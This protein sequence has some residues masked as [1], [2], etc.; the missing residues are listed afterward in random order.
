LSIQRFAVSGSTTVAV[1][2]IA[3]AI[4]DA[5]GVTARTGLR[6]NVMIPVTVNAA[7]P[8]SA[9]RPRGP[10]SRFMLVSQT[11]S[12]INVQIGGANV[13]VMGVQVALNPAVLDVG[14][15]AGGLIGS[16]VCQVMGLLGNPTMLVGVLNQLLG[17]L[18]PLI[19]GL[20]G[21]L[22]L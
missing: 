21:G 11:C 5:P 9:Y 13:D 6:A 15:N 7:V 4:V 22:L 19:G 8:I 1:A 18:V 12:D 20:S 10:A 3:G 2:A 17:Q 14:A 16:L